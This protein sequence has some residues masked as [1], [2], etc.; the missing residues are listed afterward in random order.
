MTAITTHSREK[1]R[2]RAMQGTAGIA[3]KRQAPEEPAGACVAS[4]CRPSRCLAALTAEPQ[5]RF[6]S[7]HL[8]NRSLGSS[9]RV[10]TEADS[11][12][13]DP[14]MGG[15]AKTGWPWLAGWLAACLLW[16][17]TH[18]L[19]L[20][21]QLFKGPGPSLNWAGLDPATPAPPLSHSL[22]FYQTLKAASHRLF[23]TY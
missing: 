20:P 22:N 5:P 6:L 2:H 11:S 8:S 17:A 16:S 4:T 14:G 1:P 9:P 18:T 23:S 15:L 3:K 13:S 10:P 19:T 12:R 7:L 21:A